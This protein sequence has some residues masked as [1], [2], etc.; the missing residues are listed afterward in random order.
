LRIVLNIRKGDMH[1]AEKEF[2]L[3]LKNR[4]MR[5]TDERV[6]IL[7]EAVSMGS[8]FE[9]DDIFVRLRRKKTGA[10]HA[11]V[12]RTIPLLVEAGIIRK[13]PCDHMDGRYESVFGEDHHD[14]LVC[15]RCG[16]VIEFRDDAIEK[17]QKKVA[18]KYKFKMLGHRHV[19][20]GICEKCREEK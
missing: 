4:K 9:A 20:S 11:S 1:E 17:L 13:T 10:S 16:K 6:A 15:V 18:R 19:L 3:F 14:H 8:H 5:C 2:R 12:Y 7:R